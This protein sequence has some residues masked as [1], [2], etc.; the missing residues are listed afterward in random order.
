M[1]M[2]ESFQHR[3]VDTGEG[4]I[5]CRHAGQGFPLLLLHG[6][7][8][9][10]LIW[11]KTAPALARDFTVIVP[12]LR[13][14]GDS[15][16]PPS[17][18]DHAPYSKRTMATDMVRLMDDF[19][20]NNFFIAGHDR[21]GRVAHRLARDHRDRV[22]AMA[23]LDICPTLDMYEATDMDFATAYFHWFF[24]TQPPDIPERMIASD[25]RAWMKLCLQNWSDGFDFGEL[26]DL[27]LESF[28]KPEC[29]HA[30]CE[31][32]RAAAT[33]DLEHD[34]ADRHKPVDIPLHVLWG[35][36]GVV[37]RN[38]HPLKVWAHYTTRPVTGGA[39]PCGHFIPEENPE[40]T[41]AE[42]REFFGLVVSP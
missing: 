41:V 16:T 11:H 8:Q 19:G 40:A 38:F 33:V 24:L 35:E 7:P 15:M 28:Q 36:H 4:K 6:Y 42:L 2:F 26:E 25:P 37:E 10:H 34:R 27:Y 12:D 13:G 31:D 30:S 5:F 23:V 32:Y 22:R 29:I 20:F 21:G 18:L 1:E 17:T 3:F 14:Y 9:T 39:M